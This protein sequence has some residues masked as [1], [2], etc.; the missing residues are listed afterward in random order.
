MD[1]NLLLLIVFVVLIGWMFFNSRRTRA[2]QKE[3]AELKAQ[4]M[5][6]G[7]RVMTR[8]GLFGT[9]VEFDRDDL[10][11]P[12][13]VEIAPGVVVELHSQVVDIAPDAVADEHAD[14]SAVADE[15]DEPATAVEAV[16][17]AEAETSAKTD[18]SAFPEY[19]LP[20]IDLGTDKDDEKK[21]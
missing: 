8:G 21:A 16:E 11:K 7:A 19:T 13:K 20:E 9:L 3:A 18:S 1:P 10:S 5:V 17:T 15:A 4:Q 14:D 6:P 2:K 12:A